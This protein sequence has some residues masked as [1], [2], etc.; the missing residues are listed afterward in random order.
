MVKVQIEKIA[1]L[2]G[3]RQKSTAGAP[4][5]T[6]RPCWHA[7]SLAETRS[8]AV[9]GCGQDGACRVFGVRE[10]VVGLARQGFSLAKKRYC[11]G[12]QR[13][14]ML[15]VIFGSG[16]KQDP[17]GLPRVELGSPRGKD[18]LDALPPPRQGEA[19]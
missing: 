12:R 6:W 16:R 13:D 3:I 14:N 18:F 10:K 8:G 9:E 1:R 2:P 4:N 15:A 5:I 11:P 7:G 19:A 17:Y